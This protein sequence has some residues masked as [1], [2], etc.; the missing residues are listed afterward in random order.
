M[1]YLS[2]NNNIYKNDKFFYFIDK[3]KFNNK[4][5]FTKLGKK[6]KKTYN[7]K[8]KLNTEMD[9]LINVLI[10]NGLKKN[11]TSKINKSVV[12]IYDIFFNYDIHKKNLDL[13]YFEKPN[14]LSVKKILESSFDWFI[15]NNFFPVFFENYKFIFDYKNVSLK[16]QKKNK[17]LK[18]K[19]KLEFKYINPTNRFKH[20]LPI[21]KYCISLE[22]SFYFDLRF[23]SF[24][25]NLIISGKN[26]FFLKRKTNIYNQVLKSKN[27]NN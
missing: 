4:Y 18:L 23:Y 6:F 26:D 8:N 2:I 7:K 5:F 14:F 19:P 16:T 3:Y 27:K 21:I 25:T 11:L 9:Q 20:L 1:S 10:K 22:K 15:F 13:D 24:F 17:K 12:E